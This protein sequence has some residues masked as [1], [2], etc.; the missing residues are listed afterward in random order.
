ML[1]SVGDLAP[2]FTLPSTAGGEVSLSSFRGRH[3]VLIAFFPLA[4]TSVCT[5]ELCAFSEDYAEFTGRGAVVLP[6]SVDSQ[7]TLKAFQARERITV[8]LLSDFKRTVSRRYG[9]LDEEK[10]QSRRA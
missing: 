4:F 1:P 6:I 9:V 2:D 10:F 8:D 5:T 3:H 7:P